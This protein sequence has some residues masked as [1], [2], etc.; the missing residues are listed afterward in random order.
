ML[1]NQADDNA[2]ESER[3][4]MLPALTFIQDLLVPLNFR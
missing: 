4:T 2:R 1:Y 3:L